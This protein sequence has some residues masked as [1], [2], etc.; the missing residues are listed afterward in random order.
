M[1]PSCQGDSGG[2]IILADGTDT[3]VGIVS[4]GV[5]CAHPTYP[6]V[7]ARV[8]SQ[9]S[10]IRSYVCLWAPD[11]CEGNTI[12]ETNPGDQP[13][14]TITTQFDGLNGSSGNMFDVKATINIAVVALEIHV[15]STI[16]ETVEVYTKAGTHVGEEQNYSAWTKRGE[17][18][19]IGRGEGKPTPIPNGSFHPITITKGETVAF[20]ITIRSDHFIYSDGTLVGNVLVSN[21]HLSI[22]EGIGNVYAFG[23][24]FSP[25]SWNG[26]LQ[27][28]I[29][30]E[31]SKEIDETL[32]NIEMILVGVDKLSISDQIIWANITS[33]FVDQYYNVNG[34]LARDG[35]K[36]INMI[37]ET[38]FISQDITINAGSDIVNESLRK[39]QV[40]NNTVNGL[41]EVR[42]EYSQTFRFQTDSSEANLVDVAISPFESTVQRENYVARLKQASFSFD[43][44]VAVQGPYAEESKDDNKLTKIVILAA[45]IVGAL[46]ILGVMYRISGS[47]KR[48]R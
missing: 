30:A 13:T 9:Y 15:I 41:M 35:S 37:A 20:Y 5:G 17:T 21:D 24:V 48:R 46:L 28:Q 27:Y 18:K 11:Y 33:D 45:I 10:W 8:S 12:P 4:W 1:I 34:G 16:T 47:A 6:G 32:D 29:L 43:D 40:S 39:I 7:Y 38:N 19:V 25:R 2:P 44:L 31:E 3:Q 22:Y 42:I 23:S 26:S 36:I 14:G